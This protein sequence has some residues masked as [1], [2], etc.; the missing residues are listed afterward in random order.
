MRPVTAGFDGDGTAGGTGSGGPGT[1]RPAPVI[2][3][4]ADAP[5]WVPQAVLDGGGRVGPLDGADAVIHRGGP[6]GLPELPDSVRWVQLSSAGIE[7][8]LA[9]GRIDDRR[10]WTSAAGAYAD[11]VAEHALGLLLAG[12]RGLVAAASQQDWRPDAVAP[13]VTGL[14]GTTVAVVGAG[15]IGRRIVELLVGHRVSVIAVNRSG[16]E[17]PSADSTVPASRVGEIWDR[18]DHVVL[19]APATDAT[20]RLIDASVLA[21]LKPTSWVVNIARGSLIDTA[22]LLDA[23]TDGRIA[24]AGLDVTDPEPLPP[25]HP[26]WTTPGIL[27]TPHTANPG[28]LARRSLAERIRQNVARFASGQDLLGRIDPAAGY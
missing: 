8:F 9:S 2:A 20:R 26:L 16:R 28:P 24:G 17:V 13:R 25:E 3:V 14:A 21:R 27:I 23:V 7:G 11:Q 19:A 5:D 6:G 10:V 15:G 12:V 18:V 1:G 4:P 22:A